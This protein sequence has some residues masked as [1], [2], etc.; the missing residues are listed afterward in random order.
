MPGAVGL[1]FGGTRT[2]HRLA[3]GLED[4]GWEIYDTLMWMYGS[5][6]PKSHS[7]SKAIEKASG[8]EPIGKIPAYGTIA[9]R[10]LIDNRGWNNINNALVMPPLQT[11]L[12]KTWDGY[13]TALKPAYEP[14]ILARKPRGKTYQ[15]C[16]LEHGSAG[17]N[18]D[19]CRVG[20]QGDPYRDGF[21]KGDYSFKNESRTSWNLNED[22]DPY[23]KDPHPQGRWPANLILSHHP[24]CVR[25]GVKRVKGTKPHPVYSKVEQYEGW[26]NITHKQGEVVNKYEDADGLETVEAWECVED[27]PVAM[28][29]PS[30]RFFKT[31]KV[32][33]SVFLWYNIEKQEANQCES[34]NEGRLTHGSTLTRETSGDI[35]AGVNQE[36][37]SNIG[38]LKADGCGSENTAQSQKDTKSTTETATIPTTPSATCNSSPQPGTTTITSDCEKTT[39]TSGELNT[40]DAS[41]A[42]STSPLAS[43]RGGRQEHTK[44]IVKT[45]NGMLLENGEPRI[46]SATTPICESIESEVAESRFFY[47]AKA[48]RSERNAGL[49]GFEEKRVTGQPSW[50]DEGVH[51]QT[52]KPNKPIMSR[53]FHPTVKPIALTEYLARLIR[54]PEAYLDDAVILIPFCGSGSEVIGAIKAGWRNWLGIEISEEYA[55][56]ANARIA[57]WQEQIEADRLGRAQMEMDI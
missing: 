49:E 1:F 13:G 38:N 28:I 45:A 47:C 53:N 48:S 14:I 31:V 19:E 9:S 2:S 6:F 4:A 26:G 24:D 18:I 22:G 16:A 37:G 33:N 29:G 39:R 32:D 35:D 44:D 23:R 27:C 34:E 30:A 40:G 11:D 52:G 43:F 5:G 46:E 8:I 3:C 41:D 10:E 12:A 50:L 17:L 55:A 7:I 57:Y 42:E 51:N 20:I 36:A 15:E 56:I 21:R 25:V 54:P